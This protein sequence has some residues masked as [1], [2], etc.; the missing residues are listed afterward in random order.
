[1][2]TATAPTP[3]DRRKHEPTLTKDQIKEL[4][5]VLTPPQYAEAFGFSKRYTQKAC[6]EGKLPARLVGGRYYIN[7]A[8]V[9]EMFGLA[10]TDAE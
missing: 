1:M 2:A 5:A 6:Q 3:R 8:K 10:D 4:P 9:L 7:T